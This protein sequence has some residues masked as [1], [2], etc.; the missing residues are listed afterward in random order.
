MFTIFTKKSHRQFGGA[1][2]RDILILTKKGEESQVLRAICEALAETLVLV[3][4]I[5]FAAKSPRLLSFKAGKQAPTC[6]F[7]IFQENNN[8]FTF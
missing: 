4:V 7:S 8:I 2:S 6:R 5:M 3:P 1:T